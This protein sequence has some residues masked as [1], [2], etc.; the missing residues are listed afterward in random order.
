MLEFIIVFVAFLGYPIGLVINKYIGIELKQGRKY[1]LLLK[2]FLVAVFII[3]FL[4]NAYQRYIAIILGVIVGYYYRKEFFYLGAGLAGGFF[5]LRDII[6]GLIF[7]FG[8]AYSAVSR[9]EIKFKKIFDNLLYFIMPFFIL[10]I[11]F[12]LFSTSDALAFAAGALIW[13]L[14]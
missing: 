5:Y 3:L 14:R 7:L 13:E 10:L 12:N 6:A 1:F 8:L 4:F 2:K 11:S 9:E